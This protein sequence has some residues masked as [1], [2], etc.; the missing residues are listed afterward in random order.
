MRNRRLCRHGLTGPDSPGRVRSPVIISLA[1]QKGW[2]S[3][4]SSGI[5]EC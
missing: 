4:R 1:V 3:A 2:G 5:D